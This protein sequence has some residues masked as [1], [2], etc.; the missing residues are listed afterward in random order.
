M[1]LNYVDEMN[2]RGQIL[3]ELVEPGEMVRFEAAFH[4]EGDDGLSAFSVDE[5]TLGEIVETS[6]PGVVVRVHGAMNGPE[7]STGYEDIFVKPTDVV[8][9]VD[10]RDSRIGNNRVEK[11][12]KMDIG[13]WDVVRAGVPALAGGNF[14]DKAKATAALVAWARKALHG[15]EDSAANIASK[16]H[17]AIVAL[18]EM[19]DEQWASEL[20]EQS[21]G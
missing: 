8:L 1:R 15:E 6:P 11:E 17:A 7:L 5:G 18:E 16:I 9:L 20:A 4:K 21:L 3:A 19:S 13:L 14:V 10:S 12:G 2:D